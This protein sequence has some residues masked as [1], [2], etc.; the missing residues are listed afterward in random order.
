MPAPLVPRKE[1]L[2]MRRLIIVLTAVAAVSVGATSAQATNPHYINGPDC[3]LQGG[4][5]VCSG[6]VAGLGSDPLFVVV[7]APSG[8][9]VKSG[10][11]D[12]PG[13]R[14]FVSGPFDTSNGQFTFGPGTG[15]NVTASGPNCPGTQTGFVLDSN[16]TVTLYE[17]SS[18][19]PTFSKKTGAQTNRSCSA[20][21]GPTPA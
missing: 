10:S 8:C 20:V 11:N 18:G 2:K 1:S 3:T 5:L 7:N 19:S 14:T 4:T 13:Q 21:L 15:N 12:P 16:V 6:K 17:C 9:T